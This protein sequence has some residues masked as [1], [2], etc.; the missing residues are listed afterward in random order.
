MLLFRARF[1]ASFR[2]WRSLS[3]SLFPIT[4]PTTAEATPTTAQVTALP[5]AARQPRE[6]ARPPRRAPPVAFVWSELLAQAE[7]VIA[8]TTTALILRLFINAP[9]AFSMITQLLVA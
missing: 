3:S 4:P 2:R 9:L 6:P 7:S 8:A 1:N 5:L